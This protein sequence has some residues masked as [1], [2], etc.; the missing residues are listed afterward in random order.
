MTDTLEIINCP[1]CGREMKKIY[2][3]EHDLFVDICTEGCGGIFFD[4][5]E[6]SK[7]DEK[8]EN[9]R[10]LYVETLD[11][12]FITVDE[13]EIRICPVC[14]MKM[15][16]NYSSINKTIQVDDCYGCG[17]KFLDNGELIKIR[18]EYETDKERGEA[19]IAD[20]EKQFASEM[21]R[22][23]IEGIEARNDVTNADRIATFINKNSKSTINQEKLSAFIKSYVKN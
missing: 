4:N 16:K 21:Q 1:A 18:S 12:N 7:F 2:I 19:V 11:K 5:R 6:F 14:G 8:H 15:V 23:R 20:F 17:A 9:I 22:N 13:N 3:K 10:E